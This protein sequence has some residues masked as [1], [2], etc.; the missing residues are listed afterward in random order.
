MGSDQLLRS[1]VHRGDI[2]G[3][4]R[5]VHVP[6][7]LGRTR[8]LSES[9]AVEAIH[10]AEA[11]VKSRRDYAHLLNREVIRQTIVEDA[12]DFFDRRIPMGIEV[13][14]LIPRVCAGIGAACPDDLH[15]L[16]SGFSNDTCQSALNGSPSRLRRPAAEVGAVVRDDEL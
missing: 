16:L 8:R 15:R 2:Q 14:N 12:R 9:I 13:C 7:P 4:P 10:G 11:R 5:V 3:V 1:L 6:A